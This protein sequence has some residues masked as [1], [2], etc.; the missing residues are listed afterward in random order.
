MLSGVVSK[1]GA[2]GMLRFALPLFPG[3]AADW[4]PVLLTR[5]ARRPA[6][7]L[8]RRVPAAR[9][10]RRDRV[11]VDRAD[12]P[13]HARDLRLQ[14]PG[15]HGRGVPDGQ[16][17][18]ALVAAVPA[19]R[20]GR[21]AL[22][23]RPVRPRRRARPRTAR[24]RDDLPRRRHRARSRFPGRACSHPSS[25]CCWVPSASSGWSGRSRRSRSCSR[26]CTCCAGSRR[27]L[28]DTPARAEPPASA[29]AGGIRDLRWEAVWLVPL[30]AAVLALSVVPL[31]RHPPRGRI[32]ARA[33]PR[34]RRWRP[35]SDRRPRSSSGRRSGR[36]SSC[37]CSRV[38]CCSSA[39]SS[40]GARAR[41]ISGTIS[42]LG[43]VGAGL[44]AWWLW[45]HHPNWLV[46]SGQLRVDRFAD[47]V[48]DP[49]LRG[50]ARDRRALR[51]AR[52]ACDERTRR[53]LRA[54]L[55]TRGRRACRCSRPPTACSSLF[56]ALELFSI[57]L[58][59]LCALDVWSEASLESGLKYL[60]VGSVGSAVP[61]VRLAGSCTPRPQALRF[62][63]IA[64]A[65]QANQPRRRGDAAARHRDDPR[66][67]RLQGVGCAVP[68]VDARRLRGRADRG[69][70]VHGDGDQ[71]RRAVRA[72][73]HPDDGVRA[74]R[75]RLGGS[76]RRARDRVDGHR[77][78]RRARAD[79]RQ[80]HARLQL[81]RAGRLPPDPDRREHAARRAGARSTTSPCTWR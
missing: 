9:L 41:V 53:V 24:A 43:F 75:R 11:L 7:V 32:G 72:H 59:V 38:C 45:R 6:L 10:A 57:S 29:D 58:Y 27:V 14:R 52:T 73:A 70:G 60:V 74:R 13:D 12:E 39:R 47:L 22:R 77:Q 4:Q 69:D 20:L 62:D 78:H 23:Q 19:R 80:A 16:P 79:E 34:R 36:A 49:R 17:R 5:V 31:L 50:R 33:R 54:A 71:G 21:A 46:M 81:D 42:M 25:S 64:A 37:S 56:V 2:Y 26:P 44:L 51:G 28:H 61:A 1:A 15:R 18:P 30:V 55:L 40:S 8:A 35:A 3:P 48:H 76:G 68:P 63:G 66:R 65:I 67:A